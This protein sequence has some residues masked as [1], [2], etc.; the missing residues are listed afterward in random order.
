MKLVG[1]HLW[2]ETAGIKAVTYERHEKAPTC[3]HCTDHA[4]YKH[5]DM[6]L[7]WTHAK[8]IYDIVTRMIGRLS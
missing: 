7:C 6:M 1:A 5:G 8:A 4:F 2:T 3:D